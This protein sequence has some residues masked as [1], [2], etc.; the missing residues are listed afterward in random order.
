MKNNG[1]HSSGENLNKFTRISVN[2]NNKCNLACSYCFVSE[3]PQGV[4]KDETAIRTVEFLKQHLSPTQGSGVD[5]FGK[6]PLLSPSLL[7]F[8]AHELTADGYSIGV[9]TNGTLIN[10]YLAMQFAELNMSVLLS[11]DGVQQ[12]HDRNR[13]YKNG[14]GS[15]FA[16]VRGAD[17]LIKHDV[18]FGVALTMTPESLP[19]LYTNVKAAVELGANFVAINRQNYVSFPVGKLRKAYKAVSRA[20]LRNNWQLTFT[21]SSMDLVRSPSN[22]NNPACGAARG[23]VCVHYDGK[24]YICHRAPYSSKKQYFELGNVFEGINW[25]KVNW[26]RQQRPSYCSSCVVYQQQGQC[27]HCWVMAKEINNNIYQP[28]MNDCQV[29]AVI[30][31]VAKELVAD[32][33]Q[34]D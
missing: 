29:T 18:P 31:G 30:H 1:S 4:M 32:E 34:P 24:I 19:A 14:E 11:F 15:Y 21:Q 20:A 33:T 5:L 23:G 6:E 3:E 28:V 8:I 17:Y 25:D 10:N 12:W 27:G 9:T 22:Y 26:W 2:I 13:M 7:L 16:V